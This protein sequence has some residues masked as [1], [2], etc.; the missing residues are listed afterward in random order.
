SHGAQMDEAEALFH[1]Q[2]GEDDDALEADVWRVDEGFFFDFW[3]GDGDP[4]H[5]EV[6]ERVRVPNRPLDLPTVKRL[7]DP[8]SAEVPASPRRRF[9]TRLGRGRAS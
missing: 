6:V 3:H 1:Q 5:G 7:V 9:L 8:G 2:V 4:A